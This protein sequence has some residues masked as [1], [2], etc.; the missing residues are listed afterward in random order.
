MKLENEPDLVQAQ[1]AEIGAQPAAVID[2]IAVEREPAAAVEITRIVGDDPGDTIAAGQLDQRRRQ[3]SFVSAR[4]MQLHFNGEPVS[5][6]FTPAIQL[7]I[8]FDSAVAGEQGCE[9]ARRRTSQAEE[10]SA[11]RG[12]VVECDVGLAAIGYRYGVAFG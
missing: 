2:D 5:K 12:D 11:A 1:P 8:R 7:V 10:A 3:R 6:D 9:V 4:V